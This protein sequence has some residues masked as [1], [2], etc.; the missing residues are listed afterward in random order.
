MAATSELER[1]RETL[2]EFCELVLHWTKRINLISAPSVELAWDRHVLDSAQL[3][4]V[5]Q[6]FGNHYVDIGSGGGF[7]GIVV[8]ILLREAQK[9]TEITLVESDVRKATFLRTA[10]REFDLGINVI[11]KR[12][13][14][15]PDLHASTLSARA[16]SSFNHLLG[17]A[18][19]HLDNSGTALFMKGASWEKEVADAKEHW[20]FELESRPSIT[21][22]Q[23]RILI[24]EKIRRV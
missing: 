2:E 9:D 3:F 17:Y 1:S 14:A 8:S 5:K 21:Q 7:P 20:S 13:E 4:H 22:P 6:D 11:S 10:N 15:I 19:K 12:I 23:S 16:L 24:V 18:E